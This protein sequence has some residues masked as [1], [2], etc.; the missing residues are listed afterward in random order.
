MVLH[1]VANRPHFFIKAAAA[2][3]TETFGHRDL[4][5]RDIVAVP[6]G[7]EKRIGK[8]EIQEILYGF[9]SKK[10][11]DSENGRL[12]KELMQRAVQ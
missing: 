10:M 5:A 4:H 8:T 11:I 3:D 2:L 9:L 6:N 12:R 1:D 7:F